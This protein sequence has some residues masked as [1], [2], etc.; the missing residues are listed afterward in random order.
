MSLVT[1]NFEV[2]LWQVADA[3]ID[4]SVAVDIG[5]SDDAVV[6]GKRVRQAGWDAAVAVG[7]VDG[8]GWPPASSMIPV[9]LDRKDWEY[10]VQQCDR[11]APL[12]EPGSLDLLRD[13]V[14][15]VLSA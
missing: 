11:W 13:H 9:T 1:I 8:L 12:E 15:N 14:S 6:V 10:V 7:G 3:V 5:E 2:R 4:N